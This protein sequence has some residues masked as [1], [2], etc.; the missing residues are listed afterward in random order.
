MFLS[1]VV[2]ADDCLTV[3]YND[4]YLTSSKTNSPECL[5]GQCKNI[6]SLYSRIFR[7]LMICYPIIQNNMLTLP[8]TVKEL[9][10]YNAD[11][12]K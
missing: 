9:L 2:R 4:Y 6:V 1:I 11:Q 10:C 7:I 3:V 8:I 12:Q 5:S